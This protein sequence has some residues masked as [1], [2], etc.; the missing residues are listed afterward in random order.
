VP[1]I[2]VRLDQARPSPALEF[3]ISSFQWVDAF[4]P[5]LDRRME[6]IVG[7]VKRSVDLPH[8]PVA[9]DPK[10]PLKF[11]RDYRILEL[12][13]E[14]GMSAGGTCLSGLIGGR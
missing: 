11:I 3:M 7:A 1:V 13:G 2:P 9:G 4:P 6:T 5:P 12:L 8:A 10:A 14:G